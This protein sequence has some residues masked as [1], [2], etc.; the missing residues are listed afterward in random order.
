MLSTDLHPLIKALVFFHP[1]L[2]GL[3]ENPFHLNAYIST[4]ALSVFS[5]LHGQGTTKITLSEMKGSNLVDAFELVASQTTR[6]VRPFCI[7]Y[8]EEIFTSFSKSV[9]PGSLHV[10]LPYL[11][12]LS[13]SGH[14]APLFR[15]ALSQA[16]S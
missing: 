15:C 6:N 5:S 8:F 14:A 9:R 12:F 13:P 7:A 1:D 11:G 3:R 2:V 10:H 16:R 4:V